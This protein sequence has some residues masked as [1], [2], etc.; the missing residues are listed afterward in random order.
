VIA[1][2]GRARFLFL[3]EVFMH[4]IR[5]TRSV[6]LTAI[7]LLGCALAALSQTIPGTINYQGRLTDNSPQQNP[8]TATVNMSFELWDCAACATPAPDRLWIEPASGTLPVAVTGGIFSVA[9]GGNGVAIPATAFSGGTQRWLQIYAN[10]EALAPRQMLTATGYANQ[11]QNAAT[12]ASAT[13]ATTAGNASQLGGVAAGG[14]QLATVQSCGANQFL[15]AIGSGT[16]TCTAAPANNLNPPVSLSGNLGTPL[17]TVTNSG[18]GLGLYSISTGD[19]V[20]GRTTG[21]GSGVHGSAG[22][23]SYSITNVGVQGASDAGTGTAG[24]TTTGNGVMGFATDSGTGVY[25]GSNGTGNA[26]LFQISNAASPASALSVG[27]TGTGAGISAS[28]A[29]GTGLTVSAGGTGAIVTAS[30]TDGIY[31]STTAN[32]GNGLR[33]TASNGSN[34]YG[35]WGDSS[36]GYGVVG[37]SATGTGVMGQTS[38]SVAKATAVSGN[39]TAASGS[40]SGV[41]G[42]ATSSPNGSGVTGKGFL[43]GGYFE[44]TGNM[45]AFTNSYG[46]YGL[47]DSNNGYSIGVYGQ[48]NA[49]PEGYGLDGNGSYMGVLGQGGTFGVF[50]Q[51]TS[52]TG[53]GV[54][55]QAP[56]LGKGIY[57][58][59]SSG[60]A[61]AGYFNGN[62]SVVGTLSKSSGSFKIDHPL[63]P[64]NKYLYHSFVESPDMMN[65]YN[66][67]IVTD[68]N[69]VAVVGLPDWFGALNRDF[70]YQLTVIGEFA[71]AIIAREIENNHFII[72]TSKPG[73]KVSWQVTGIRKDAYAEAHRI[74]VEEDKPADELGT[75]LHPIEQGQ[76]AENALGYEER[77][78]LELKLPA[79]AAASVGTPPPSPAVALPKK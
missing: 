57:G 75:F 46:V 58:T 23:A 17:L 12:A 28:S 19:G 53:Y 11:A 43:N 63:D 22:A 27:T 76:P 6:T 61:Y 36:A 59:A 73:V 40:I 65:L 54:Y 67:N 70:R 51:A 20:Y 10:G 35:A 50:G 69:A 79:H 13:T 3:I 2:A 37:T 52:L 78:A 45:P 66:G 25:G 5:H 74:P 72:R 30:G 4:A 62:V 34:A 9:L 1:A 56:S 16:A 42:T 48:A 29:G 8:L 14:Y 41:T 60:S 71:Q 38:S 21:S 47:N 68:E 31:V 15:S 64:A 33:A 55:G 24:I 26:G 44:S 77:H 49:G 32:G 18:T 7:A 39:A